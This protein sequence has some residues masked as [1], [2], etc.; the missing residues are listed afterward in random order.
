MR[1]IHG[2]FFDFTNCDLNEDRIVSFERGIT[3][4]AVFGVRAAKANFVPPSRH[5]KRKRPP[6]L[7]GPLFL[8]SSY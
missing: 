7:Q 4:K 1:Q 8:E 5:A 3:S 6:R 2:Q